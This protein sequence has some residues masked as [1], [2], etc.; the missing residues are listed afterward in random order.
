MHRLF[1]VLFVFS[2]LLSL[3]QTDPKLLHTKNKSAIK[4]YQQAELLQLQRKFFEAL[5]VYHMAIDKDPNFAEAYYKIGGMFL[6][7]GKVKEGKPYLVKGVQLLPNEK[8][9]A[10]IYY[11]LADVYLL[12]GAYDSAV[13]LYQMSL[14]VKPNDKR[15]VTQAPRQIERCLFAKEL[16][17]HPVPFNPTKMKAPMNIL[18][19][20]S[21][22]ITTADGN[23]FIF[24]AR[25]GNRGMDSEE[26]MLCKWNGTNWSKPLSI[27]S[28]INTEKNEGT[29]TI[30][31]DGKTMVFV[32]CSRTDGLGSCDLYITYFENG[33]WSVP[34]N[35]GSNINSNSWDSHPSLSS[36][37]RELYFTSTRIGGKGKED[38]YKSSL[39]ENGIWSK[40]VN[41]GAPINT[42]GGEHSPFIHADNQTLFFASNEHMGMGGFD[43]FMTSKQ[44][45]SWAKPTNLGYPINTPQND[46]TIFI[47][48][49]GKKGYFSKWESGDINTSPIYLYEFDVPNSL[50][51]K[52]KSTFINGHLF[53]A[54]TKKPIK[55]FVELIDLNSK[56]VIQRVHSDSLSGIYTCVLT[57]GK[58]YG[59]FVQSN[60]YLYQT[61]HI[62]FIQAHQFDPLSMDIYLNKLIVGASITMN[63]IFFASNAY[64]LEPQSLVELDKLITML[65][66]NPSI[67]IEISGHTD[68]IGNEASNKTLSENRANAVFIYLN[69]NGIE[70]SRLKKVGYGSLKP[71]AE[72]TSEKGK[73]Q[74]RRIEL[75]VIA[76]K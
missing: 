30:S 70:A 72:N 65:K 51:A 33:D 32:G 16:I 73:Q 34:Q 60:G 3:A 27:S 35:M 53:D 61:Q 36:D 9:F 8:V 68:N 15:I 19:A 47:R 10:G 40:A 14:D 5:D 37:G 71:I 57:E 45:T 66:A 1:T 31:Q 55:G 2:T 49:D 44:D 20:Q 7:Y 23:S 64:T 4:L 48:L 50:Q 42:V 39:D 18:F 24:T 21:H 54:Q 46:E 26:I 62:D 59:L 67:K 28:A 12:E 29:C 63:N 13:V 25:A 69:K 11:S 75:K 17:Q 74:N 41:L 76:L 6:S 43:L 38:I 22:P 58:D 56:K 52:N